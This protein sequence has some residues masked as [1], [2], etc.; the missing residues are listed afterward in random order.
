MTLFKLEGSRLVSVNDETGNPVA[1]ADMQ[2]KSGGHDVLFIP[3]DI[4]I[5]GTGK[6]FNPFRI[7]ILEFPVFKDGRA[8]TQAVTLREHFGFT[9]NL[10]ATGNILRDQFFFMARCG[11]DMFRIDSS[12]SR[13]MQD[14]L[15]EFSFS[16]QTCTDNTAPVWKRRLEDF[17]ASRGHS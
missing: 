6:N 15:H 17:S 16:Y 1:F 14:A 11:F 9:G 7:I 2:E 3:N 13:T 5:S 12:Q 8:Y 10:C 4:Q